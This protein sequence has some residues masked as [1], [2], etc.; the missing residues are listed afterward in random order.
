MSD[1]KK[2]EDPTMIPEDDLE[3]VSAGFKL[4]DLRIGGDDL[5]NSFDAIDPR[6][7]TI[8]AKETK[9]LLSSRFKSSKGFI[10]F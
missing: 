10:K 5:V 8:T 3:N 2:N 6:A 9:D 7:E 1:E 4:G